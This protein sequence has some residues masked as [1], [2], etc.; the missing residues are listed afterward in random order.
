[1]PHAKKSLGQHWL[2]DQASLEAVAQAADIGSQDVVLEVGPGLGTL[3]AELVKLSKQ[4]IAVEYDTALAARL[5]AQLTAPNLTIV[6]GDILSYDLTQLPPGYKV[7]ANIPYYLTSHLLR[8]LCESP[9]PPN[10]TALL[11]QKEVAERVVA[12]PGQMSLLSVSVQ[13]YCDTSLGQVIPASLFSPPPKVDSQILKLVY[14]GPKFGNVDTKEFFRL[15]KAG[16]SS[17]R[18]KLRG[19]LS[20]GLRTTKAEA[21]ELLSRAQID[22]NLRA[23]NLSLDDWHALYKALS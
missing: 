10:Q 16:F 20:A 6:Q 22:P 17:R 9:N 4:V 14:R 13:F 5:K 7:A 18:K 1:M 8:L 11:V 19:S 2:Y 12:G 3:T 21:D 23:Q 15:V